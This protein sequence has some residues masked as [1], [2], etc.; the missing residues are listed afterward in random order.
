MINHAQKAA[1]PM[2]RRRRLR[3]TEEGTILSWRRAS[4]RFVAWQDIQL[5]VTG[6]CDPGLARSARDGGPSA[7]PA[8]HMDE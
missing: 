8:R 4:I 7:L 2:G 6:V 5:P 3:I 1:D